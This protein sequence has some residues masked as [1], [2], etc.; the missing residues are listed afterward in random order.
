MTKKSDQCI[1]VES[2]LIKKTAEG[3][4]KEEEAAVKEHL[5]SHPRV[6]HFY[7]DRQGRVVRA[8]REKSWETFV[9]FRAQPVYQETSG[10]LKNAVGSF[11]TAPSYFN[12]ANYI[13]NIPYKID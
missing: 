6:G 13:G 8:E 7:R 11:L 10:E 5:E 9:M 2:L 12:E 4:G 1:L 3:L